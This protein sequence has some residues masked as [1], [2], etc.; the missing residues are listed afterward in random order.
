MTGMRPDACVRRLWKVTTEWPRILLD[1]ASCIGITEQRLVRAA[2]GSQQD[3]EAL[4]RSIRWAQQT[5]RR[6]AFLAEMLAHVAHIVAED[7][8]YYQA[9]LHKLA[10]T[11]KEMIELSK[12]GEKCSS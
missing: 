10:H 12:N 8:A 3:I 2:K 7:S 1:A 9:K 4:E 11:C 6:M 5:A